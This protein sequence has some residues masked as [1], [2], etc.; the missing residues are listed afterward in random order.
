[1]WSRSATWLAWSGVLLL[2]LSGESALA[3]VTLTGPLAPVTVLEGDDFFTTV[4]HNRL[5][6]NERRDFMWEENWQEGTINMAGGLW[7]GQ[8]NTQGAYVFPILPGF[9]DAVPFG[10][11]GRSMGESL[12]VDSAKYKYLAVRRSVNNRTAQAVYVKNTAVFPSS[13]ADLVCTGSDGYFPTG[14][15]AVLFP[16]NV[17]TIDTYDFR[18]ANLNPTRCQGGSNAPWTGTIRALRLDPSTQGPMNTSVSYDWVRLVDPTS[19]PNVTIT[20]TP[21]AGT[22][23]VNIYVDDNNSGNNGSFIGRAAASAGTFSFPS[24]A[25][26]PGTWFFYLERRNNLPGD[27]S[28]GFSGYSAAYTV[29][30]RTTVTINNPSM[31]SGPDY[32]TDVLGNAWDFSEPAPN[33]DIISMTQI[34]SPTFSGGAFTGTGVKPGGQSVTDAQFRLRIGTPILTRRFRYLSVDMSID[35]TGYTN[36]TNKL[37]NG[38]LANPFFW[39]QT[40]E[41]DG[42][43]ARGTVV[44]EGRHVY[45]YDLA[46]PFVRRLPSQRGWLGNATVSTLRYDPLETT[47]NNTPFSMFDM[48]I[49]AR[50]EPNAA[51]SLTLQVTT[52]DPEG[53][54][55]SIQ[56]FRDNDAA[57][58][59][60][61]LLANIVSGAPGLRTAIISTASLFAGDHFV[62]VEVTEPPHGIVTRQYADA[63][64][65][66]SPQVWHNFFAVN[67][68]ETPFVGDFNGDGRTDIITF[69]RQN[70]ASFGDVYVSLSDGTQFLPSTK[71]ND[72]FA[73]NTSEQV[74][75]GDY[76][77]DNKD[78]I[79]TWLSASTRQVYV[80]LS[81]GT[82]MTSATVWSN[83]IGFDPSNVLAA[84]DADGD[85]KKDLILFARAQRKVYVAISD[86]TKFAPPVVWH[87]F[88]AVSNF[89]RPRVADVDGDGRADI[90]T[91]ATDSPSAFGD[92]YT[93]LSDGTKFG[94]GQN[95]N[96][97]HD[98][99]AIRPTEEIRIGDLDEDGKDDFFTFLPGP[100]GQCYTVL[101]QGTGMGPNDLWMAEDLVYLNTDKPFVGDVNADGKADI[102]LFSQVPGIV[103]VVLTPP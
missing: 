101:S 75:I 37:S 47:I 93:A 14:A 96:K 24:A 64:I 74:V 13:G 34:G 90:V 97:W 54:N 21:I 27:A 33:P 53:N 84:G 78:D 45:T 73:I 35:P 76:D 23:A 55:S 29:N 44:Y 4:A 36:I 3:Q 48:R 89:E 42:T 41:A 102:I 71:W 11:E 87:N 65:H 63:P 25:L 8:F 22:A 79:A 68:L 31:T 40:F 19:G 5:D 43:E 30:G 1:M 77:G 15:P 70:P 7:T 9:S 6:L 81:L 67:S 85:G 72:F 17:F 50:P 39:N 98:F 80:A 91:F 57:G 52:S 10:P 66:I 92:V 51:N 100:F 99:F 103:K 94:D 69:T 26:A 56:F 49:R 46:S 83:S 86:G 82:G 58:F 38:H 28:Q 2:G 95:S 59:N 88:F 16:A 60:G 61:T 12:G 62:Y 18:N 32:A 20:W